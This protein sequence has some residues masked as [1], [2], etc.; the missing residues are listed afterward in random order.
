[1]TTNTSTCPS[2][3]TLAQYLDGSLSPKERAEVEAH[4]AACEDCFEQ[5]AAVA[6]LE[7]EREHAVAARGGEIKRLA[8]TRSRWLAA[9]A[10][11][12]LGIGWWSWTADDGVPRRQM[13]GEE[14]LQADD[15]A[16]LR[17]VDDGTWRRQVDNGALL[18]QPDGAAR[19]QAIAA[20]RQADDAARRQAAAASLAWAE[21]LG[22][23]QD[24]RAAAARGWSR[25]AL[26]FNDGS[27]PP[28]KRGFRLGVHLLD[29]RTAAAARDDAGWLVALA[30]A[31]PL[32]PRE[33][34]ATTERLARP[35][36]RVD[37]SA[38]REEIKQ[39]P[40][41]FLLRLDDVS[42]RRQEIERLA[43]SARMVDPMAFDLGAWTEAGRLA[44]MGGKPDLLA[45]PAYQA[46][47]DEFLRRALDSRDVN[48]QRELTAIRPYL[49][50]ERSP[51]DMADLARAFETI[52]L[53]H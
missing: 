20:L 12:V 45:D 37:V 26:A 8:P 47:L 10:V 38:R 6:V 43:V 21:R 33:V 50:K 25:Q 28:E 31:A 1:M 53:K 48:V 32:L 14:P 34:D 4:I 36:E 19:R 11:L 51:D 41:A 24:L 3:E 52:I 27:L 46:R 7:T 5:V 39:G 30:D 9:A 22:S 13:V 15:G 35:R 18:R 42:A 23:E 49:Q 2:A 40:G 44:A 16:L 17:Q 29:A